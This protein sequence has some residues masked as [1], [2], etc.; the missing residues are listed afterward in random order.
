MGIV[1]LHDSAAPHL[2]LS[3]HGVLLLGQV[4]FPLPEGPTPQ[5]HPKKMLPQPL[6]LQSSQRSSLPRH[7][8]WDLQKEQCCPRRSSVTGW[9]SFTHKALR[10]SH[11]ASP[12]PTVS[13]TETQ[14]SQFSTQT[15]IPIVFCKFTNLTYLHPLSMIP[16]PSTTFYDGTLKEGWKPCLNLLKLKPPADQQIK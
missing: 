9:H 15:V 12:L 3:L 14:A 2:V 13:S 16:D 11:H 10:R 1:T 6:T 7:Q 5:L 8:H 4:G